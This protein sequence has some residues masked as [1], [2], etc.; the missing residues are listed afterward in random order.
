[1][2]HFIAFQKK[3]ALY[4][5]PGAAT[6]EELAHALNH[7]LMAVGF[8]LSQPAF[9]LVGEQ[10]GYEPIYR[11]FPQSVLALSYREFLL[12]A[13]VHYWT[14]GA[15]RPEDAD[16]LQREFG[17]EPVSYREIGVLTESRFQQIFTDLLYSDISLSAF[18]KTCID[19]YIEQGGAFD[20][21]RITF[22]ETAAYVGQRLLAAELDRLPTR[23]ATTVLRI[24]SAWSGGDEGLTANTRYKSPSVAHRRLLLA[25]LDRCVDLEDSFKTHRERWLR[26]LFYLH[27]LAPAARQ[28]YPTLGE[29]AD[30]LRNHPATLRTWNSRVE[31]AIAAKSPELFGLLAARPGAFMRRL[32]HLVR[33]FGIE[34]FLQWLALGPRFDQL[35]TVYNHFYGRAQDQGARGAVL[36][37]QAKS[38]LVTYAAVAPLPA[39]LVES[40]V[41]RL[42]ERLRNFTVAE[43][44]GPAYIDPG[45]YHTP[46]ATNNRASS[47]TLDGKALGT[48]EVYAAQQT[49]RVYV[50]WE[51]PSD[52]DLSGFTISRANEVQKIGWNGAH[53]AGDYIVY[54]GDNTGLAAK[55]AEYLD[56]NTAELPED[57]DWIIVEA[58]IFRG[59]PSF[60]GYEGKVHMGWMSRA[61][62]RANKQWLP[63]TLERATVL[64]NEGTVA[65]LLAY[66]RASKR[67]V[68]LDMS[69]GSSAVST[70]HD[71]IRMRGF[72]RGF[73]SF[74]EGDGGDG[75]DGHSWARLNQGHVLELLAPAR[76]PTPVG[77]EFLFNEDTTAEQVSRLMKL[78]E[79]RD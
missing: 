27:P 44:Q 79:P 33:L 50:H 13:I 56:I 10:G 78:A 25:T 7:E 21:A 36:A 3:K 60:A 11:G 41:A 69:M 15:W 31:L 57:I 34:A 46:L 30:R 72:L 5:Q 40:I 70:A 59:P 2:R 24:W 37:S 14:G 12:N 65:Y 28:A 51:G 71:A 6:N 77:A 17:R 26:L 39:A 64:R 20:F 22:K 47:L 48:T 54:S 1:M 23:S 38:E 9:A 66:H 67:I 62:P 16:Y 76:A 53:R 75:G 32:D 52:I 19:W 63:K 55:N 74:N 35:V 29:Y 4:L 45:L 8:V 49:L 61:A 58:R 42:L 68:Y 18:D 73:V 43:L